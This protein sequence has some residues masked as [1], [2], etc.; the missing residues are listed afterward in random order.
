MTLLRP[1]MLLLG[2]A[3]AFVLALALTLQWR[4]LSRLGR[5]Y[6]DEVARRLM[7][8]TVQQFPTARMVYL[9][10]ASLALGT[11]AAGPRP[12]TPEPPEP[13]TP[14]DIAVAVDVSLSMSA[15]DVEPTR[16]ERARVVVDRISESLPSAR[17]VL[18]LFADWPY[19]LVPP[20]DD[21]AVVRYFARSL[22]ADVVMDRDQGTSLSTALTHAR[23]ALDAR[24]RDG[25]RRAI[26][27]LS[28]GGAHE[29]L[30]AV[31]EAAATASADGVPIWTAGLG[32]PGGAPL[33]TEAGPVIDA[34]GRPVVATL[35]ETLLREIARAGGG[36][37]QDVSDER[38]LRGL[39]DELGAL[40]DASEGESDAPLDASFWLTLLAVPLLLWEG[41]LDAGRGVPA[42][43]GSRT[44]A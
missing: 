9:M 15:A 22:S 6:G 19:T 12:T 42:P 31:L 34:A 38:G 4:R 27:V 7:P 17:I 24:P 37:Y 28:D 1:E 2:P 23:T 21:P 14:L 25:A 32:T 20:T 26:L 29:E 11:A 10:V 36:D 35:D 40:D 16:I 5:S 39:L 18:I 3:A 13:A 8:R 44:D 30:G 33:A 43:R 41:G